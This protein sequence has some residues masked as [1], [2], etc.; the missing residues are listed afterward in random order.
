MVAFSSL[1]AATAAVAGVSATAANGESL[2][3]RLSTSSTGTASDGFYYSFWT[4][5]SSGVDYEDGDNGKYS[6]TWE[7]SSVDFV[8]GK[9]WA[10]GSERYASQK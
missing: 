10:T 6:V 2:H 5:V 9:G 7:S 4:E 8:A 3:K 1:I